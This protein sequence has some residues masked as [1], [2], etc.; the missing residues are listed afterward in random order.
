VSIVVLSKDYKELLRRLGEEPDPNDTV[1]GNAREV[2]LEDLLKGAWEEL[3]EAGEAGLVFLASQ[4]PG[5][6]YIRG[7]W[8]SCGDGKPV[9]VNVNADGCPVVCVNKDGPIPDSLKNAMRYFRALKKAQ[10]IM[11]LGK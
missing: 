1:T 2:E 4:G 6:D 7:D 9:F 10:K 8:A 5:Y 11:G 3:K